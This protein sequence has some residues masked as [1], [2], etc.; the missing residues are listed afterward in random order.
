MAVFSR[1][2]LIVVLL[3]FVLHGR[4]HACLEFLGR[5]APSTELRRR[6]ADVTQNNVGGWI[7]MRSSVGDS[8]PLQYNSN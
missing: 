3:E 2:I 8:A 7:V 1:H 5:M 4:T 6:P